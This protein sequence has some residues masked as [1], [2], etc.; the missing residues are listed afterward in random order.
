MADQALG[1][2]KLCRRCAKIALQELQYCPRCGS[3]TWT[4]VSERLAGL[5]H[6]ESKGGDHLSIVPWTTADVAKGIIFF[7]AQAAMV[8]LLFILVI[9]LVEDLRLGF[10]ALLV[11]FLIEFILVTAV[12]LF[13]VSKYRISWSALGLWKGPGGLGVMLAAAALVAGL[14]VQVIYLRLLELIG[15]DT[16]GATPSTFLEEGGVLLVLLS[17][18]A[19]LVAPFAEELFFRG[20]VFVG[21]ANRFGFWWGAVGSAAVFSL[22]HIEPVKI[23]PLFILGLLLAWVYYKTGSL[24][25]PVLMHFLNNGIALAVVL[26]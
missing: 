8:S 4:P 16:T 18:L 12:W 2:W 26:A 6:S 25:T 11:T 21:L 22:V 17:L 9:I 1:E 3:D 15:V 5:P 10:Y 7:L 20:F 23:F 14:A 24:W 19:L 13:A